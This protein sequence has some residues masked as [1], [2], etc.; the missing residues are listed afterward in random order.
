M[1]D[2]AYETCVG[3]CAWCWECLPAAGESHAVCR[4]TSGHPLELRF[5]HR[6]WPVYLS[7]SGLERRAP[8]EWTAQRVEELRIRGGYNTADFARRVKCNPE[9]LRRYLGGDSSALTPT[10]K[11]QLRSLATELRFSRGTKIDWEDARAFFCL[12]RHM[13]WTILAAAN[14]LG[15]SETA[16]KEWQEN[17]VPRSNP[18]TWAKLTRVA[19]KNGFDAGMVL[20]DRCWTPELLARAIGRCGQPVSIW[21][22][23]AGLTEHSIRNYRTGRD[24]ITRNAAY[25]LTRAAT[26]LGATLPPVGR[27][28][29]S[30][31]PQARHRPLERKKRW[32]PDMIA[33][34]GAM[35]DSEVARRL[36]LRTSAV[37]KQR[38]RLGIAAF[39]SGV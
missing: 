15:S 4:T 22:A 39:G 26:L 35:P 27:V 25:A 34:L 16:V 30:R 29:Y 10:L 3:R 2:I 19:E 11:R 38:G 9:R 5:H 17:G 14:S 28:P 8:E 21:A 13:N 31:P 36:G 37:A 12:C 20:E 7:T 6:C 32:T 24:S 33:L 23:R 18:S 1:Y